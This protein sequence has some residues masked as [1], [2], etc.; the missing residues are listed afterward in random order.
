MRRI[1]WDLRLSE[2]GSVAPTVALS[3]IALIGAGGLAFDYA[4]LATMDTEL[5]NAA[6][7]AALAGASQL[8]KKTG[9]C[10]RANAAIQTLV[11]NRT[12]FANDGN[13]SGMAVTIPSE[14]PCDATGSVRFYQNSAK[15]Q[16]A[17]SDA[18]AKF[19]EVQ[20]NARQA[21][22]ALTP[23]VGALQS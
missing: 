23:I 21:R 9:A 5:Q 8:D 12:L 3:L 17:T 1:P 2:K 14:A 18:N 16:A 20:V 10:A 4:R 11:T 22:Y 19:V 6:D 13:A 7:H 15:T